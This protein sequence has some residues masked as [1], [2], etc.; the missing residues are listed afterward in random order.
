MYCFVTPEVGK[1]D[2][3]SVDRFQEARGSSAM[4]YVGPAGF[5][6]AGHVEAVGFG[7]KFR[8]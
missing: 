6:D 1:A 8:L 7:E 4:L 2:G 3:V 5:A